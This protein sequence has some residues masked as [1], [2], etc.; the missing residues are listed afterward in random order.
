MENTNKI[1]VVQ[2]SALQHGE[3]M[4]PAADENEAIEIA[5]KA[6]SEGKVFLHDG[7]LANLFAIEWRC[8]EKN[9]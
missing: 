2:L 1:Y 9:I 6:Y 4:T 8:T 7:K 5:K 3:I